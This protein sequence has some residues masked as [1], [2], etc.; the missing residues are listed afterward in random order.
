MALF[1]SQSGTWKRCPGPYSALCRPAIP[2]PWSLGMAGAHSYRLDPAEGFHS[3]PRSANFGPFDL[4]LEPAN[5][6]LG[7]TPFAFRRTGTARH[8]AFL[9][10][11]NTAV[12]HLWSLHNWLEVAAQGLTLCPLADMFIDEDLV[13]PVAL[14]LSG[15]AG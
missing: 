1:T 9:T 12:V 8:P 15:G 11:S 3:P 6:R 4:G 10:R 7:F 14:P 5:V 13:Q 2:P